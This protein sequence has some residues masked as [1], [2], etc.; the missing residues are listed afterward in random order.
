M[1]NLVSKIKKEILKITLGVVI[2]VP[3]LYGMASLE[4]HFAYKDHNA[5]FQEFAQK[6]PSVAYGIALNQIKVGHP[7]YFLPD[8]E[9]KISKDYIKSFKGDK[10]TGEKWSREHPDKHFGALYEND[11][12]LLSPF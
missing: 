12:G 7:L 6:D 4:S 5:A 9:L 1:K 8:D 3:V 2:G 10:V 11:S